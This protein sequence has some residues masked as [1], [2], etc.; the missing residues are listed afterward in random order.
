ME[1]SGAY[2][3]NALAANGSES[4]ES[5]QSG[6]VW[7]QR[8]SPAAS[9][10][11]SARHP[12]TLEWSPTIESHRQLVAVNLYRGGLSAMVFPDQPRRASFSVEALI[13]SAHDCASI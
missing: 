11:V 6:G 7:R 5:A 3:R 4:K 2:R 1:R 8:T 10:I 13:L 12:P 9:V